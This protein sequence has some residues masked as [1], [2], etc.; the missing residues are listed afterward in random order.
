[1][2]V[3]NG[4]FTLA[5]FTSVWMVVVYMGALNTC[6]GTSYFNK[7]RNELKRVASGGETHHY[8]INDKT[9]ISDCFGQDGTST[10]SE[11]PGEGAT[12]APP[13]GGAGSTRA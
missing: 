10:G 12:A 13:A 4:T 11:P 5:R 8:H 3:T 9:Y 2:L 7:G 1:M 6:K